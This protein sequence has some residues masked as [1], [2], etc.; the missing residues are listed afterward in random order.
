MV[1]GGGKAANKAFHVSKNASYVILAVLLEAGFIV[2]LLARKYL[3]IVGLNT[4][5]PMD[6]AGDYLQSVSTAIILAAGFVLGF[7]I[8]SKV[9]SRVG[10]VIAIPLAAVESLAYPLVVPFLVLGTAV[11]Y[12]G[13]EVVFG[14]LLIYGRRL[15]YVFLTISVVVMTQLI[16][17]M[18]LPAFSLSFIIP[19]IISYNLHV[20]REKRKSIYVAVLYF[21]GLVALGALIIKFWGVVP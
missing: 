14:A 6:L 19:G 4:M 12:F 11:C 18:Q 9:G 3:E 21:L 13:G 5:G 1:L 2:L 10:G 15:F 16:V 7:V 8:Y 17:V 20:D